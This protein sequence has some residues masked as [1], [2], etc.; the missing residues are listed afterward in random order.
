MFANI[1]KKKC[2][3]PLHRT[4]RGLS[5]VTSK[6]HLTTKQL[7]IFCKIHQTYPNISKHHIS[8]EP[9][10][11]LKACSSLTLLPLNHLTISSKE[12]LLELGR[13][14]W[15]SHTPARAFESVRRKRKNNERITSSWTT[16]ND[17]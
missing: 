6:Q 8:I 11:K 10:S 7:G 16:R 4:Q 17:K 5:L 15:W 2:H 1:A 3:L 14:G 13:P 12:R 9:I